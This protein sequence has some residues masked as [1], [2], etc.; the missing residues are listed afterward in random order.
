MCCHYYCVDASL[1][2]ISKLLLHCTDCTRYQFPPKDN[3]YSAVYQVHTAVFQLLLYCC[4]LVMSIL[5]VY[6]YDE[7]LF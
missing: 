5:T 1:S 4:L 2:L 6:T 7:P 3:S